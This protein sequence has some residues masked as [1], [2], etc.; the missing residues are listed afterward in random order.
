VFGNATHRKEVNAMEKLEGQN[1]PEVE[2]LTLEE[3]SIEELE[4]RLELLRISDGNC[5]C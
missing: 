2:D 3:F 4:D 1:K 5:S